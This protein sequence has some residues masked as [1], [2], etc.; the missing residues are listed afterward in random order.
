[1]RRVVRSTLACVSFRRNYGA[2]AAAAPAETPDVDGA[3]STTEEALVS[4][5]ARAVLVGM[6]GDLKAARS[7]GLVPLARAYFDKNGVRPVVGSAGAYLELARGDETVVAE[8]QRV[9]AERSQV[10][11]NLVTTELE[12]LWESDYACFRRDSP[13]LLSRNAELTAKIDRYLVFDFETTTKVSRKRIASPFDSDNRIVYAAWAHHSDGQPCVQRVAETGDWWCFPDLSDVDVLVGHNI[14]F[15]LLYC[16][17]HPKIREFFKRG[18]MVWDT[19]YAEFL[20]RGHREGSLRLDSLALNYGFDLKDSAISDAWKAGIDTP[21]ID[22]TLMEEYNKQD[23]AVTR[24]IFRKQFECLRDGL[25]LP[26]VTGH[27]EGLLATTEM[28]FR[29]L[30]V[31]QEHLKE[32]RALA[33]TR[34]DEIKEELVQ[35]EPKEIK[36]LNAQDDSR[37]F[38]FNWDSP[39]QLR[40]WLFGG[41]CS[42]LSAAKAPS[43]GAKGKKAPTNTKA[44]LTFEVGRAAVWK[45]R[46]GQRYIA[47]GSVVPG[48][49]Q[50]VLESIRARA[51]DEELRTL[52]ELILQRRQIRKIDATYLDNFER[53]ADD[54]GLVHHQLNHCVA[55]TGRLTSQNPNMQNVPRETTTADFPVKACLTSRFGDKGVVIESD[56]SQV[57]VFVLATL[58]QDSNLLQELRMGTDLHCKRLALKEHMEYE[59]VVKL[60]KKVKDP[61]WVAKRQQA[62]SFQFQRQYGAG[63][64]AIAL[65]T[66]LTV[67]EVEELI[68]LEERTYPEV[69]SYYKRVH[70]CLED[71]SD[72]TTGDPDFGWYDAPT[73]CRFF[74][75]KE[76]EGSMFG[77]IGGKKAFKRQLVLNHPIQGFAAEL[78]FNS[79]GRLWR[80]FVELNNYG[81]RAYLVNTVHDCVWVD[82]HEDVAQQVIDDLNSI[83]TAVQETFTPQG[84][85]IEEWPQ[86]RC[87]THAGRNMASLDLAYKFFSA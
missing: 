17:N 50:E 41:S 66:G 64:N 9:I 44:Q 39:N 43:D 47:P 35:R 80:R 31:D 54:D 22:Q 37:V 62:K 79:L 4:G 55:R 3:E 20:L 59:E 19:M 29:G 25:R 63:K 28:E 56:Y 52:V 74:F 60:C 27:M 34:E 14:K 78:L 33:K 76:D 53:L 87:E 86:Y 70:S 5:L 75:K 61:V 45:Q 23:V 26:M 8:V 73:G 48:A 7:K 11:R 51:D 1:M 83:L 16:W 84:V 46:Y 72:R 67:A 24:G 10:T 21:D 42:V 69:A 81:D 40:C 38:E 71:T 77:R 15:D 18:G 6:T 12:P 68:D 49:T 30:Y 65:N 58:S 2:A 82:A 32:L 36:E 85:Q 57:E 13:L